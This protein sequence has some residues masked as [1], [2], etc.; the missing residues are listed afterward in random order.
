[1]ILFVILIV[2][3]VAVATLRILMLESQMRH[4]RNE[5]E[6]LK[7]PLPLSLERAP[8]SGTAKFTHQTRFGL[9]DIDLHR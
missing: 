4:M 6:V 7:V 3:F 9:I 8:I 2:V 1:M 5:I